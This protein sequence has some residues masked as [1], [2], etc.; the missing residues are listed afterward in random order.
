MANTRTPS[1]QTLRLLAAMVERP[2]D[3][4]HGYDLAKAAGLSSGAL[5]PQLARLHERGIL[6]AEW[7]APEQPGRPARHVY[8]LTRAGLDL[9]RSLQDAQSVRPL[10][11]AFA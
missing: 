3:W 5:Y 9:A 4:R 7:R 1:P 10:K 2:L 6:E 8:R 11:E